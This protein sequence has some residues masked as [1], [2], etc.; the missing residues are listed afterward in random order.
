MIPFV[1]L[2]LVG[3]IEFGLILNDVIAV[4]QGTRE[5]ARQG[6][7]AQF[8]NASCTLANPGTND[9]NTRS[10]MC[11]AK[12]QIGLADDDVR[13]KILIDRPELDQPATDGFKVDNGLVLCT[14]YQLRSRTR[15]LSPFLDGRATKTKTAYRIEQENPAVVAA[16][17]DSLSGESWSWCT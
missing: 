13:V 3:I 4:R 16:S 8:G 7:V 17:E 2:L 15:L 14:Q 6:A 11:L 12:A 1:F 5:A 9:A 10:L